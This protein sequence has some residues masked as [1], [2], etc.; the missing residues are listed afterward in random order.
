MRSSK[1]DKTILRKGEKLKRKIDKRLVKS[2]KCIKCGKRKTIHHYFCNSC[3]EIKQR[4][5]N[6]R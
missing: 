2:K 6:G 4:R 3:W 1:I 5:K